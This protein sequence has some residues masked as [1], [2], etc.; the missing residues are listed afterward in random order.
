MS[1]NAVVEQMRLTGRQTVPGIARDLIGHGWTE[2]GVEVELHRLLREGEVTRRVRHGA[3]H[4][5]WRPAHQ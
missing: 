2:L 4:D 5:L 1:T 3:W